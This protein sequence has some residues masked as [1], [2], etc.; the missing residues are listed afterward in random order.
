MNSYHISTKCIQE[1]YKPKNGE[2]RVMPLFQ[3]TTYKYDSSDHLGKLFDLAEPGHMYSR[4]SNP[5]NECVEGKIN[6]LEGGVGALLTS[7]GQAA[8]LITILNLCK[9]GQNFLAS[10]AIYGGTITLMSAELNRMGIEVRY[11]NQNET[12]EQIQARIDENTRLV[13]GETIANP[14]LEI[15]DIERFVLLAH[16]NRIPL[17]VD[18]TFATPYL[19]RPFEYGCDIIVHSTTKYMDGHASQ[20]G[21]VI[22]DSGRFDYK[23]GKFPEFT[24]PNESYHG[25]VFAEQFGNA[26]FIAKARTLLMR[27]LG[28]TASPFNSYLVNMGLETLPLRMERHCSNAMK[29]AQYLSNRTDKISR[30]IYPGL[31]SDPN[32]A[33]AVKYL[34]N[35]DGKFIGSC[36]VISFEVKGGRPAAVK[37]M[38]SLKLAAIVVHVADSRTSVLHPASTT[39]RQLTDEQLVA[40]GITSGMIRF[41]VGIE[42]SDD[43]IEDIRQALDKI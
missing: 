18:N 15:Y 42:H 2:P 24:C 35:E 28:S 30:V 39:H 7:S 31:E 41:S 33:L 40:C 3:S 38:D 5:T 37:F 13:Y 34:H 1:G 32:H 12:D 17:C 19:C 21:G 14:A 43:I 36:G 9:N 23:N 16:K 10:S 27:D 29:V 11:F 22:I 25:V 6:A 8:I 20:I 4:I 26:A